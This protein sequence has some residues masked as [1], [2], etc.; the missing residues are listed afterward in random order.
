MV[1]G[2]L[3]GLFSTVLT[4]EPVPQE[5]LFFGQLSFGKW[6]PYQVAQSDDRWDNHGQ[7]CGMNLTTTV[8]KQLCFP[9][10]QEDNRSL[11]VADVYRLVVEI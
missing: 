4:N 11:H 6:A 5:Y 8:F 10:A 2:Q 3:P 9:L 1:E 7:G